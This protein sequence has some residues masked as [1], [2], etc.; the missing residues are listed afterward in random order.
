M[1][2]ASLVRRILAWT[3]AALAAVL[4]LAAGLVTAVNA[5]YGHALLVRA[6]AARVH[7]PV[8]VN[9]TLQAHLFLRHPQIVAEHVT[10]DNPPWMPAGRAAE[11]GRVSMQLQLPGFSHRAGI[12]ALEV[13]AATLYLA[14]DAIGHANWQ[15]TYPPKTAANKDAPIIR[16]L[17]VPNAHVILN[18]A[19]RHLQ[20]DGTVSVQDPSGRAAPQPLRIAGSG[21][22]NGR[23]DSF[24]LT[25]DSLATASHERP[26]HFTFLERS[27]GSRIEGRGLLSQPFAYDV[28]DAT[29]EAVGPDLKDLYF[30]TG[31]HLID[32]G[33]YRLTGRVSRRQK[34]TVF[35]D[36]VAKSGQSDMRGTV[37][38]DATDIR[39]KL[40]IDLDSQLLRLSDLGIRAAGRATEPKSPLLLSDAMLSLTMLRT[41]DANVKFRAHELEVGRL[42]IQAVSAKA[43]MDHGVLTV[44]PLSAQVLGGRVNAH[45]KFDAEPQTPTAK[46]DVRITDLQLGQFPYKDPDHPP[47]EGPMQA[48]VSLTGAG[49]S[50]HEVAASAN[51]TVTTQLPHGSLRDSFAELTGLDLRGL[52]LLLTRNKREVPIR[53]AIAKFSIHQG[54]LVVQSLIADTEPVLITGEGQIHLDSES[55]D[56]DIRGRPK[57]VRLFRLRA[58]ITVRGTLAHPSLGIQTSKS[59]FK[60]VDPGAAE[61]ADCPAL[62]AGG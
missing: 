36:L 31:V 59:A 1:R 3:V 12:V 11:I 21:Q 16:S 23:A 60:V 2:A 62:L 45:L 53:C 10:I 34:H 39:R 22:L 52:G 30:L 6:V 27:S 37:A 56:L 61:D 4:M 20:F 14:R 44:A 15:L 58:P 43:T 41:R 29:F 7:R 40:D 50:I 8:Q 17:T 57:K 28:V 5:G 42:T 47:V 24:E 33:D 18:D 51:G 26:Y 46:I 25:A 48:Q 54:T 9:G 55:L 49:S 32:T 35:S 38:I 19:L 13:E